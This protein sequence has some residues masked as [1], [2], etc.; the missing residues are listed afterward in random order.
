MEWTKENRLKLALQLLFHM[1]ESSLGRVPK[2]SF[3]SETI[4]S[5]LIAPEKFLRKNLSDLTMLKITYSGVKNISDKEIWEV[6]KKDINE[7]YPGQFSE[8]ELRKVK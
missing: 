2:C 7:I 4:L 3:N 6:M 5:I 8:E 1:R